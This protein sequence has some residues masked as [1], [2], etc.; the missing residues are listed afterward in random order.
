VWI[1]ETH[2]EGKQNNHGRQR[3]EGTWMREERGEGKRRGRIRYGRNRRDAQRIRRINQ[4]M[5]QWSLGGQ[6]KPLESPRDLGSE[7]L[8]GLNGD[9]ISQNAQQ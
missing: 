3:E 1:T 5:R 2:L 8:P 4:N 6:G 7:R 9:D